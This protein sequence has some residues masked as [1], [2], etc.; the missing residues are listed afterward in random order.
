MVEYNVLAS[1]A[2]WLKHR[3]GIGG[4]DAAAVIG[5]HPYMSNVDLFKIKTGQ[6]EHTIAD[7]KAV[8]YGTNAEPLLRALFA[9][10]FPQFKVDYAENNMWHNGKYPFAHASLDGW[11]TDEQGHKGILEIKTAN[12]M[13]SAQRAKWDDK[14]PDNYYCQILHYLAVTE[15]DFACLKAQLKTEYGGEVRLQTKHYW[16]ERAE[17]GQDIDYLMEREAEF[18]KCLEK[19]QCP[20]LI[21]PKI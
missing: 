14:I 21:L 12:I 16:I 4:S 6:M 8:E 18:A 13:Q 11:L 3:T 10:D 5:M 1:R 15:F 20:S 7:A 17:V 2:D 19:E 9:L